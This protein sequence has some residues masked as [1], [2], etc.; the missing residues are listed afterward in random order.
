MKELLTERQCI[1]MID[2]L[3]SQ[4]QIGLFG[5]YIISNKQLRINFIDASNGSYQRDFD[6]F[7]LLINDEVFSQKSTRF[8]KFDFENKICH[9]TAYFDMMFGEIE[10]CQNG[11]CDWNKSVSVLFEFLKNQIKLYLNDVSYE[12]KEVMEITGKYNNLIKKEVDIFFENKIN[13]ICTC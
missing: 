1:K 3:V 8:I 12:F 7:D 6:K 10:C 4:K 13:E 11:I 2:Y 5:S 9:W